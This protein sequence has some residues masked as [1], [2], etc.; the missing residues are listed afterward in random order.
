MVQSHTQ[1]SAATAPATADVAPVVAGGRAPRDAL[2]EG[3]KDLEGQRSGLVSARRAIVSQLD[4]SPARSEQRRILTDRVR[5]MDSRIATLDG[6]L[7][8]TGT[9][10]DVAP[11]TTVV[12]VPPPPASPD[13]PPI[14]GEYFDLGVVFMLVFVLPMS[15]ALARRIW[16]RGESSAP[17]ISS[18]IAQRLGRMEQAMEATA[19]EVERIGEGQ[20]FLTRMLAQRGEPAPLLRRGEHDKTPTS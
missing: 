4:Q 2:L 6:Q 13:F 20:R 19:I 1:P 15:I 18:D 16:R 11:V 8:L 9:Q 14:P 7:A 5:E 12:S 3:L 10:S 17:A